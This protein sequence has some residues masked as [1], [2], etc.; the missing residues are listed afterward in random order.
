M[1]HSSLPSI[2]FLITILGAAAAQASNEEKPLRWVTVGGYGEVRATPDEAALRFTVEKRLPTV[3]QAQSEVTEI[4]QSVITT[5]QSEGVARKDIQSTGL[6]VQPNYQWNRKAEKQELIGYI[7]RREVTAQLRDLARLGAIMQGAVTAGVTQIQPPSLEF[8]NRERLLQQALSNA[9]ANARDKARVLA[10][11]LGAQ[12]GPVQS[13]QSGGLVTQPPPMPMRSQ[14][15][16]MSAEAAPVA[17][18]SWQPGE[19]DLSANV[20]VQFAITD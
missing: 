14:M 3:A 1:K 19:Q 4:V 6:N 12:L 17:D 9:A 5:L 20:T 15:R 10:E 13:I 16:V 18:K 8:S 11:T 7:V 2:F